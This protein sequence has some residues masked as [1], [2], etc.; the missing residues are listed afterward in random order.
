VVGREMR[1]MIDEPRE[2]ARI[3][4]ELQPAYAAMTV[5]PPCVSVKCALDMLGQGVGGV[6]LPMVEASPDEAVEIRERL[7]AVGLLERV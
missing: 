3:D 5:A 6:R 1:R 4:A 7:A 2:R